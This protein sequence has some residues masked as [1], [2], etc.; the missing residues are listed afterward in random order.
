M[1]VKKSKLPNHQYIQILSIQL[2]LLWD[3]QSFPEIFHL[4]FIQK[5][6]H[7]FLQLCYSDIQSEF[8]DYHE[9]KEP[10]PLPIAQRHGGMTGEE[11]CVL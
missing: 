10:E 8:T 2:Y 7:I 5:V 9:K 1:G 4:C 6:K 11:N 3:A